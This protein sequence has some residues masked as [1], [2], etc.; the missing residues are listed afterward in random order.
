[1]RQVMEKSYILEHIDIEVNHECNLNCIHC[2]ACASMEKNEKA[3]NNK[4]IE[5]I[6]SGAKRIGLKRVGL[7]GGEPLMDLEKLSTVAYMC[8]DQLGLPLHIHTNGTLVTQEMVKPNGVLTLFEAISITF[9]GANAQAHD[10]VTRQTGSFESALRSTKILVDSGLPLTCFFVPIHSRSD[11]FDSLAEKLADLGVEKIRALALAPSGRARS[12]FSEAVPNS[13]EIARLEGVLQEA[14][15][16]YGMCVEAGYCTRLLIRR[17]AV[18]SG[19]EKCTSGLDRLHVN[20]KG[21]VFPCTAAS[22][23]EE[24]KIGN[25][26][27]SNFNLQVIWRE[28]PKLNAIR[29]LHS[30]LLPE[31]DECSQERKCRDGCMVNTCGTMAEKLQIHCPLLMPI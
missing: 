5:T 23:I 3:L 26:R 22:G 29:A 19:H 6:L 31:C 16:H 7:T 13:D 9:L 10:E 11:S 15:N 20:Y 28:S 18:L 14:R 27:E 4:E 2:S 17:L 24:L 30:G 1:M 21:D 25:V 12:I 8:R